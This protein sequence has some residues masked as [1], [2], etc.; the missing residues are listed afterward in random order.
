MITEIQL[1]NITWVNPLGQNTNL[2]DRTAFVESVSHTMEFNAFPNSLTFSN[3]ATYPNTKQKL[4]MSKL[5][6]LTGLAKYD[7]V[8]TKNKTTRQENEVYSYTKNLQN[9]L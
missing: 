7:S 6:C 5:P 3:L 1:Q 4:M 9:T 8:Q 2:I